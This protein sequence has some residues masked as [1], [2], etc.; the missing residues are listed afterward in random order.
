MRNRDAQRVDGPFDVRVDHQVELFVRDVKDR[1]AT[2]YAR[3]RAHAVDSAEALDRGLDRRNDVGFRAGVPVHEEDLGTVA[4]E[5]PGRFVVDVHENDVPAVGVKLPYRSGADAGGAARDEEC[6]A[7][8]KDASCK[9]I[10]DTSI[11]GAHV[12][13]STS[14]KRETPEKSGVSRE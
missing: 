13:R 4:D 14:Q 7:G 8:H 5:R 3:V 6:L 12:S 11:L 9:Y 10:R 2:V 1:V